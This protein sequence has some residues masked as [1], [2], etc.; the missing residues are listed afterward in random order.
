[1][2]Y[3][4]STIS[5][6]YSHYQQNMK[7]SPFKFQGNSSKQ[8]KGAKNSAAETEDGKGKQ[9]MSP[10]DMKKAAPRVK[11][12]TQTRSA[13]PVNTPRPSAKG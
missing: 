6:T 10:K 9:A 12:N 11:M 5:I 7:Q 3:L 13:R 2:V 4:L 8:V 1:M